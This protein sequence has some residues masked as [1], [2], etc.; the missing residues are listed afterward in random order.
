MWRVSGFLSEAECD[1]VKEAYLPTFTSCFPGAPETLVWWLGRW[2]SW[3][4]IRVCQEMNQELERGAGYGNELLEVIEK[5]IHNTLREANL[6]LGKDG[7]GMGFA[8]ESMDF[9]I[10]RY[11]RGGKFRYHYDETM[12]AEALPLTFMVYLSDKPEGGGGGDKFSK[13]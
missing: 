7:Q 4:S 9:Q 8:T 3:G 12:D 13:S 1:Y 6:Y 5:R 10:V 2:A 11:R